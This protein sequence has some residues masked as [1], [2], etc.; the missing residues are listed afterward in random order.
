MDEFAEKFGGLQNL[1]HFN[2]QACLLSIVNWSGQELFVHWTVE[3][4]PRPT[5]ETCMS[6]EKQGCYKRGFTSIGPSTICF[7]PKESLFEQYAM[8]ATTTDML[9]MGIR[10]SSWTHS[11]RLSILIIR[12]D[13]CLLRLM[14]HSILLNK[15]ASRHRVA[16]KTC[17]LA[18]HLSSNALNFVKGR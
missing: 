15:T 12:P 5:C 10:A 7:L 3:E 16:M 2:L 14:P 1:V 13:F 11:S 8:I 18:P 17:S 6:R 4:R 9:R